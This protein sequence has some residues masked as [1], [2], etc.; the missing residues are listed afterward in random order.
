MEIE[1]DFIFRRLFL[2]CQNLRMHVWEFL[3][4]GKTVP[5]FTTMTISWFL[6]HFILFFY[7]C[8]SLQF[9]IYRIAIPIL[10]YYYLRTNNCNRSV[11]S[12]PYRQ[13]LKNISIHTVCRKNDDNDVIDEKNVVS[14]FPMLLHYNKH[15]CH[16][17]QYGFLFSIGISAI[18]V[19][20]VGSNI[21]LSR[22][23][24]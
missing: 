15:I 7:L 3:K 4:R 8:N 11:L 23:V 9:T 18:V 10:L 21:H 2:T 20:V 24:H 13:S 5:R 22:D 12:L 19:G 14:V 1:S 17:R 16:P 6:L